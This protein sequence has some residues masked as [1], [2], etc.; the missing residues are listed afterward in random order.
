MSAPDL[1]IRHANPMDIP[2][3]RLIYA[4]A[5][6]NTAATMDTEEPTLATQTDWFYH[7]ETCHPILVA[8]LEGRVVGW[9]SLSAWSPKGGY[10]YTAEASVYVSHQWQRQGIGGTLL[11]ELVDRARTAGFH[12]L[13]ARIATS[14]ETS[15]K[16]VRNV[17][18]EDVGT[19]REVGH[20]FGK[21]VDV[22]VLEMLLNEPRDTSHF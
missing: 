19:M 7:H 16:L 14:N 22:Q 18:F 2:A 21:P 11:V 15:L 13:L 4:H 8:E 5:V 1:S 17:G 10:R 3:I 9:A 20:K 12:V 6:T